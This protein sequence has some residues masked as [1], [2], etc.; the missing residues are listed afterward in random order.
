MLINQCFRRF[1]RS[2]QYLFFNH[3]FD[4]RRGHQ[5]IIIIKRE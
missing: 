2:K 4:S 5:K 3:G 1:T